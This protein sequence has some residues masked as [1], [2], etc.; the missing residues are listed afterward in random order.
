[1]NNTPFAFMAP[2]GAAPAPGIVTSGLAQHFD[3]HDTA[4]YP[5]SGTQWF[6]LVSLGTT[7]YKFDLFN[8]VS[9]STDYGGSLLF[10]GTNQYARQTGT[11]TTLN[12]P[13]GDDFTVQMFLRMGTAMSS[14]NGEIFGKWSGNSGAYNY[15]IRWAYSTG[16]MQTKMY[17]GATCNPTANNTTPAVSQV[18]LLT[19]RV[20][21]TTNIMDGISSAGGTIDSN[22][23]INCLSTINNN[24]NLTLMMRGNNNN[25][26]QGNLIAFLIYNRAL[27]DAEIT[28]N[29]DYYL[30]R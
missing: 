25:W 3:V 19:Q 11:N 12:Y 15:A 4:S 14:K 27:S 28:Q 2:Q 23:T 30:N 29:Y 26:V 17:N 7:N 24:D 5:G 16:Q 22:N 18:D 6:D 21:W 8:G 13:K 20:N 9:Y 10:N 1:M